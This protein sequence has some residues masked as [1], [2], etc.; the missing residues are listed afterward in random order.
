MRRKPSFFEH[1][2][3]TSLLQAL[4]EIH[5]TAWDTPAVTIGPK[6]QQD[7]I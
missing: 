7:A 5:T 6:D 2:P 3:N 4:S 1:L